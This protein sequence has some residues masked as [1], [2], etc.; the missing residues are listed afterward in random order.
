MSNIPSAFNKVHEE[1][2]EFRSSVGTSL[3]TKVGG[4]INQGLD[5]ASPVPLGSIE[6][7][8][9]TELQFQ[10]V[11]NDGW[12]LCDGRS[13]AGSALASLTG[14]TTAPDSRG[15]FLRGKDNGAGQD[16]NGDLPIGTQVADSFQSHSHSSSISSPDGTVTGTGYFTVAAGT[17]RAGVFPTDANAAITIAL[18]PAGGPE[19]RPNNVTVN[20]FIRIN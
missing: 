17:I 18:N 9:L 6:M 2:T 16:P 15:R 8:M 20:F 1:E 10:A 14:S 7:S 19:S 4:T 3:L 13:I 11:R 12:I 5:N